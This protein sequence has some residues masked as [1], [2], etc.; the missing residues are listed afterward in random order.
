MQLKTVLA[1]VSA[2]YLMIL[3]LILE[4]YLEYELSYGYLV[5]AYYNDTDNVTHG[6]YRELSHCQTYPSYIYTKYPK[7]VAHACQS[8]VLKNLTVVSYLNNTNT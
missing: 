8:T 3:P 7:P 5:Y 6:A 1:F 2:L 4:S